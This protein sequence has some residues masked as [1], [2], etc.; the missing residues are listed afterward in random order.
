M[1]DIHSLYG[2]WCEKAVLDADLIEELESVKG[3]EEAIL[4]RFY[5]D[6]EFGTG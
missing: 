3:D 2:L 5:K 4:D 6:L 1:N